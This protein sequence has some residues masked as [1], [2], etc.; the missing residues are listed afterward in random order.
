MC[1]RN[2]ASLRIVPWHRTLV[3]VR[4]RVGSPARALSAAAVALMLV[5][6]A[7]KP[8]VEFTV[9]VPAGV[10]DARGRFTEICCEVLKEHGP[11]LLGFV[12]ADHRA[13]AVPVDRSHPAIGSTLVNHNGYPREALL[14][15]VLR[16]VEED[17]AT[18]GTPP[19]AH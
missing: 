14:E 3:A 7:T 5:A 19:R 4:H 10:T 18:G 12:N 2:C 15:A 11:A 16:F 13:I 6:C 17:L 1:S 9:E 8:P